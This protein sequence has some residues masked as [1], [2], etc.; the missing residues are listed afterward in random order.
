MFSVHMFSV[1]IIVQLHMHEY[2][3]KY[4]CMHTYKS[5]A[6]YYNT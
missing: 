1:H 5:C 2:K 6:E 3:Y 4:N